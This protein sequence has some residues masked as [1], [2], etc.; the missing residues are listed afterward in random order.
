M[1][2]HRLLRARKVDAHDTCVQGEHLCRPGRDGCALHPRFVR[3]VVLCSAWVQLTLPRSRPTLYTSSSYEDTIDVDIEQSYIV[4]RLASC[5][6]QRSLTLVSGRHHSRHP[7]LGH[8]HRRLI[9]RESGSGQSRRAYRRHAPVLLHHSPSSRRSS[10]RGITSRS[11]L[12]FFSQKPRPVKE[13]QLNLSER[14]AIYI[15]DNFLE[16]VRSDTS[17][18]ARAHSWSS[19]CGRRSRT[20]S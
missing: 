18:F 7:G 11:R 14:L 20:S 9:L 1:S 10:P 3:R 16:C 12:T 4:R 13:P 17:T 19:V 2:T 6:T 8:G 5:G 15:W